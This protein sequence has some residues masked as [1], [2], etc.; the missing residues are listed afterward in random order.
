MVML[1]EYKKEKLENLKFWGENL[2]FVSCLIAVKYL[3]MV[4]RLK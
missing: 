1:D 4:L 2:H 3:L